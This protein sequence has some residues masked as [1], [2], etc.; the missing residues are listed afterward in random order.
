M[1]V[2][3]IIKSTMSKASWSYWSKWRNWIGATNIY[4]VIHVDHTHYNI[5]LL[6]HMDHTRYN[7][8]LVTLMD[9]REQCINHDSSCSFFH[10]LNFSFEYG[11][12]NSKRRAFV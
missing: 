3:E 7:I 9:P 6:I 10:I 12:F 11:V 2:I 5:Y 8:Y 4:P 1:N